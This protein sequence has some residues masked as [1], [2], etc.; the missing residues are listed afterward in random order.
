LGAVRRSVAE[1]LAEWI[2]R[3]WI[4]KR[5]E[6]Y[7]ILEHEPLRQLAEPIRDSLC[8]QIGMP[9]DHLPGEHRLSEATLQLLSGPGSHAGRRYPV[10]DSVVVGTKAPSVVVV[11]DERVS[12]QHCRVFRGSTGS[13]YWVEDLQS[14]NGTFLN[15]RP[16][17]RAVLRDGDR[18][19][20]GGIE[21]G[22]EERPVP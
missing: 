5:R 10:G 2:K 9:L 17:R 11:A 13:R 14:L 19:R 8:Y 12:E 22:F 3:G 4:E 16:V 21:I 7:V 15:G 20:V 6:H 18:I 1:T